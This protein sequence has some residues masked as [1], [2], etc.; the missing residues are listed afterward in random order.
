MVK[1]PIMTTADSKF[2]ITLGDNCVQTFQW[3]D[4]IRQ[5]FSFMVIHK[6]RFLAVYPTIYL[7]KRNF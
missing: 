5:K 2:V 6:T 7:P 4:N 1:A 3:G